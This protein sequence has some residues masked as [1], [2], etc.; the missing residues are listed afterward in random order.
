MNTDPSY[1]EAL[2][3]DTPLPAALCDLDALEHNVD[4]LVRAIGPR[5]ITMRLATKSV[6]HIGLMQRILARGAG[7]ISGLMAYAASELSCLVDAGFRD[8]LLAYPVARRP[9]AR[10]IADAAARGAICRCVVDSAE[11]LPVLAA[12]AAER[13]VV[14]PLVIDVDLSLR[15][16]PLH[17][18]VRRSPVRSAAGALSLA[19]QIRAAK[20]LRLDGVMA[21]EAQIA[22]M[23]ATDP[24]R[25]AIHARSRPLALSRR[26]EVVAALRGAGFELSLVNGG[27]T[28]S[29]AFTASDP[30]VTEVTAGS[31]FLCPHLFD[32]Y[33]LLPAAFFALAVTRIPDTSF[34]TCSGGGFIASGPTG[35]DRS[36]QIVSPGLSP[37]PLEGFG[38][39]QTPLR[40]KGVPPSVGQIVLARHAKAGELAERFSSYLLFRGDKVEA[41]EPTYR[42]M[43]VCAP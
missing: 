9:E 2:L 33:D 35:A 25:K 28:G 14:L 20:G 18:G 32:G 43:G 4:H 7:K 34:V 37:L 23:R 38:E 11:Q 22:G 31:G 36:P 5:D 13:S 8:I 6:R 27:G 39:V 12:A 19:E 17:L 15:V 41:I 29:V 40:A 10:L 16:G 1:L 21:Y 3:T 24:I 42:G 30:S 26:A